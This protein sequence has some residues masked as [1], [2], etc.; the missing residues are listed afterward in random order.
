[1][2]ILIVTQ[3]VDSKDPILGFFHRWIIEFAKN[4]EKVTVIALGVGE[5]S[6]PENVE[7]FSLGKERGVGRFSYIKN[8][9]AYILSQR[10]EYDVVFVHMNPVYVILGFLPWKLFNKRISLWYVHKRVD[11]KLRLA[12]LLV[13]TIFTASKESFRIASP[14]VLVTG[15]GIDVDVTRPTVR[16][17]TDTKVVATLGRISEVKNI[18]FMLRVFAEAQKKSLT[19]SRFEIVGEASSYVEKAYK[20]KLLRLIDE[21]GLTRN[22]IFKGPIAN[23]L[24]SEYIGTVDVTFNAS[25]TGSL[26]K[27]VLESMAVGV[28]VLTTNEAFREMLSPYGLYGTPSDVPGNAA[29]L[30][31]LLQGESVDTAALRTLIEEQHSLKKL[32]TLIASHI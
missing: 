14:K 13:N 8:F 17:S 9:Y 12:T 18:D 27:A 29:R 26:D 22:V 11:A 24:V 19:P 1:M 4:F 7:V 25:S 30:A 2:K 6:F 20:E 16:H 23:N 5:Y 21:L 3:T 15:H 10:K 32:I 31:K 28:P